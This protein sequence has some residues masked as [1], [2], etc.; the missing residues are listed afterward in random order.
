MLSFC[1][2]SFSRFFSKQLQ[3]QPLGPR[4]LIQVESNAEKVG[5][6]FV[7]ETAQQ[8]SNQG[9]VKAVGPGRF[10]NGKLIPS[11][12]KV[13]DRVL[14]PQFGGQ[15]VKFEKKEYTIIDEEAILAV[16]E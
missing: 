5:K 13:G 12:L 3:I 16:F 9:V 8:Q 2:P 1:A 4:V 14:L 6:L 11:T 10:E 15:V 7:P